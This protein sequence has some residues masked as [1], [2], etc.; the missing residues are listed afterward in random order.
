MGT[1][2]DTL[3]G[4]RAR[5]LVTHDADEL[6]IIVALTT[7]LHN[8]LRASRPSIVGWQLV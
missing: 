8:E 7:L 6:A 3:D 4:L 1:I 5:L 2:Q